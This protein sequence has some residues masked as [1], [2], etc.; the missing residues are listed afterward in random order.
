MQD[1][2]DGKIKLLVC[3]DVAGR[4]IDI[5]NISHVFNFDVPMHA[6]DYVHRIG[7]TGRAGQD[8]HAWMLATKSEQKY[9]DAIE[10]RIKTKI[11][12]VSMNAKSGSAKSGGGSGANKGG[13]QTPKPKPSHKAA[14]VQKKRY[15]GDKK[16]QSQSKKQ[17]DTRKTG[18]NDKSV[19]GF[20]DDVPS[21]LK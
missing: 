4:G 14:P 6:D 9:V 17:T 18:S 10:A 11:P 8:G 19:V 2:K 7:R 20:G 15:E 13:N 16:P 21:F 12:V 1:F 3:S 5:K